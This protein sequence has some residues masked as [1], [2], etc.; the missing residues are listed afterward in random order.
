MKNK[1]I[2]LAIIL[3]ILNSC[4]SKKII[5]EYKDRIVKDSIYITNDRYI[6][7]QINDTIVVNSVCDSLGNLKDFDRQ[8]LSNNVK[9]SLK[10]IKGDIQAAVN[11]DSLVNSKITKFKQNYKVVKEIKEVK[12]TKYKTPLYLWMLIIIEGLIIFLLIRFK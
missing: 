12:I 4:A 8:I 11:I 9:V 6:T 7:K 2:L 3:L 10:S 5:T 1:T